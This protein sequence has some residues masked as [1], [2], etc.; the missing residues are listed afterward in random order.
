MVTFYPKS[1]EEFEWSWIC[2][3][4]NKIC[5]AHRVGLQSSIPRRL[6]IEDG[7]LKIL[8]VIQ[9]ETSSQNKMLKVPGIYNSVLKNLPRLLGDP[10]SKPN[11]HKEKELFLL[12]LPRLKW[13]QCAYWQSGEVTS[14]SL[15]SN[16]SLT[17]VKMFPW[18]ESLA[19]FQFQENISDCLYKK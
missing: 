9:S 11:T 13:S 7:K 4:E 18:Q 5:Y 15:V 10:G 8:S 19:S 6:R 14:T 3:K 2:F 17:E 1:C 16:K 12:S